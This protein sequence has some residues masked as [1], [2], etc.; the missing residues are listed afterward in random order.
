MIITGSG[1][2]EAGGW[3]HQK[4]EVREST[5]KASTTKRREQTEPKGVVNRHKMWDTWVSVT[6]DR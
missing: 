4:Q 5:E 2:S 3:T 6:G 1:S